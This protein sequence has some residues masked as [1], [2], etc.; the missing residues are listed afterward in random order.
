MQLVICFNLSETSADFT[1]DISL[2]GLWAV[3]EVN[4]AVL[5]CKFGHAGPALHQC[6][7]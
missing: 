7:F 6:E 4:V 1:W 5:C 3:L 2:V